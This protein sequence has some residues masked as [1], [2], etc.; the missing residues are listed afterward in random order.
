M[1]FFSISKLVAFHFNNRTVDDNQGK[2]N[3][4]LEGWMEKSDMFESLG[5]IGD[6]KCKSPV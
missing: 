5:G 6:K 2:T 1:N 3:F 4:N